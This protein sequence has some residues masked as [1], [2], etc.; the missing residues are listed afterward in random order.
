MSF[1]VSTAFAEASTHAAAPVS[2]AVGGGMPQIAILVGFL[3]IFYLLLWRPQA[4]R[5][6]EQRQLLSALTV[7]DEVNTSGGISGKIAKIEG[8]VLQLEIAP[9]VKVYLQKQAVVSV[10]PKGTLQFG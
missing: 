2:A 7:N 8:N 3:L 9:G 1:L 4:K 10:L 6:K 5:A